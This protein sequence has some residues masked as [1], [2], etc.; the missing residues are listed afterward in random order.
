MNNNVTKTIKRLE[1]AYITAISF[2]AI[3]LIIGQFVTQNFF[4]NQKDD[5]KV[6]NISGRQRMLSQKITKE[7]L[8]YY[9]NNL[10]KNQQDIL[11]NTFQLFETSHL[12]LIKKSN[13][14]GFS[15]HYEISPK[16]NS[17]YDSLDISFQKL[18][19]NIS[20]L[21]RQNVDSLSKKTALN[22]ILEAEKEFLPIMN[23]IVFE[24][25]AEA[26]VKLDLLRR[27]EIGVVTLSILVLLIVVFLIFRPVVRK[28]KSSMMQVVEMNNDLEA[29][30]EEL[31]SAEEE[32]RQNLE[33]LKTSQENLMNLQAEQQKFISL[34]E[35]VDAFI[36]ITSLEGKI[37]YLNAAGKRMTGLD[38]EYEDK[39]I[40]NFYDD[41]ILKKVIEIATP[42]T[43]EN[44]EWNGECNIVNT[45]TSEVFNTLISTFLLTDSHTQKPTARAIVQTDITKRKKVEEY[46]KLLHTLINNI[47]DAL[48]VATKDG[49]FIYMNEV[50]LNRLGLEG[51][52]ITKYTV[53]DIEPA[54]K[55]DGA[56][57]K[58]IEA[59]KAAGTL[60]V[61]SRNI[62]KKT[63]KEFPVEVSVKY[64]EIN[65]KGFMVA[66]SRDITEQLNKEQRIQR[67]NEQL[68]IIQ[69][70]LRQKT[71]ELEVINIALNQSTILSIADKKGHITKIND[72][73]CK[74]SKYTEAEL[75]GK[76][77]NIVNSN[78]HPKEFW[79]KMWQTITRGNTWR[80]EVKNKAKDGSI[81]WVDT[82][83]NPLFNADGKITGYL[84]IR[85]LI[86][87]KKLAE[88]KLLQQKNEI[89][90]AYKELKSAQKQLVQA[91]KMASLG[92]LV[93]NIAHE[94]NTPLGAIRSSSVSIETVLIKVL[95]ALPN[96][97]QALDET[98]LSTFNKFLVKSIHKRNT[99]SS[100][101]KRRIKYSL[102]E[103]FETL[104][105][106]DEE[107][108]AN[109]IT[110][111]GMYEEKELFMPLL[112][113]NHPE[114]LKKQIFEMLSELSIVIR[115]N[116]TIKEATRRAAKTVFA[117]KSFAR[118][119][120]SEEKQ[121]VHLNKTIETTLTL[122]NNQIKQGID[123]IRKLEDIPTFLGYPDELMQVWTNIIHN[124]IQAMKGKG[125]LFV[126]TKKQDDK[127]T[128]SI[129]DTGSG[130]PKEIQDRIFEAF[131]TTKP[132][133]EGSGLG[134]DITKKVVA[135]HDGK[136]WFETEEGIGTTFFIE[137]PL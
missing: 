64:V 43:L 62:D 12:N 97:I 51:K 32:L 28:T 36:A 99:L 5:A 40:T 132:T 93:A 7:A 111:M 49:K 130:I 25:E 52:D 46:Q 124:A 107:F 2:V 86:T 39:I 34:V 20:V 14:F 121:E 135:R 45:T 57:E 33:E 37:K 100:R 68:K 13:S 59:V 82:V 79:Q 30:N 38:D 103:K 67:Q 89:E 3:A 128:V 44:G 95:P 102:V 4:D 116:H 84:S 73:F 24:Y 85:N 56:W 96:F 15:E 65:D 113:S 17:Y 110:D 47:S 126:S 58:Y 21:T 118:Q 16:I 41:E 76:D 81:Y 27:I 125:E 18:K 104:D 60:V 11:L 69:E 61:R 50:S 63:N 115:S 117:L 19:E 70:Y 22:N 9:N 91:E 106:W 72:K 98:T 77:H 88:E 54:F 122:Y 80:A 75:T 42:S 31:T 55:E 129:R 92:Q 83:I 1:I 53:A 108:Y 120:H 105:V 8:I 23:R 26:N 48:Q 66:I 119:E 114:E 10:D 123:V 87:D 90:S 71:Q 6:I 134:L 133:G 29:T 137:I 109:L 101:E 112:D 127:V 74:I 94:I 78:Y 131:F 35:H 136:I